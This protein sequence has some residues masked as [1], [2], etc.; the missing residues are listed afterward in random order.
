METM[1]EIV[2]NVA[3]ILGMVLAFIVAG[4]GYKLVATFQRKCDTETKQMI[5]KIVVYACEQLYEGFDGDEKLQAAKEKLTELFE[6]YEIDFS[7]TELRMLI[8]SA[9]KKMNDDNTSNNML[10]DLFMSDGDEEEDDDIYNNPDNKTIYIVS[11]VE[12]L[13]KNPE[14]GLTY[15]VGTDIGK[16]FTQYESNSEGIWIPV[17]TEEV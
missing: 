13:P 11:S 5:S 7:G 16:G 12:K 10:N 4:V 9:V 2:F 15:L 14:P 8:E 17:K 6:D 3:S 1:Y